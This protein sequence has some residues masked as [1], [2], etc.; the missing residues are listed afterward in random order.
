MILLLR[1]VLVCMAVSDYVVAD[2]CI[3]DVFVTCELKEQARLK[4]AH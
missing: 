3:L 4:E 2:C 1:T